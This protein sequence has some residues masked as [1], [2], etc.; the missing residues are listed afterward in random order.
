MIVNND[1]TKALEC[2]MSMDSKTV[3]VI[4]SKI[5]P[6]SKCVAKKMGGNGPVIK[7]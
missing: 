3:K 7:N 1:M 6:I 2:G 4:I 5:E